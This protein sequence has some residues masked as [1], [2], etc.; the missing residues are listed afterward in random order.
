MQ[1]EASE[2]TIQNLEFF[3]FL[4]ACLLII[5]VI[6]EVWKIWSKDKDRH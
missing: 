3:V 1:A 2:S 6:F 4:L 5:D